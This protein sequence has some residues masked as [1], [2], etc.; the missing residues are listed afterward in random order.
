[1]VAL[2]FVL[3]SSMAFNALRS[4][5]PDQ[6][7]QRMGGSLRVAAMGGGPAAEL[8]PG[9]TCHSEDDWVQGYVDGNS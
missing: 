2:R 1:M 9:L 7:K 4:F 8:P 5:A 3:R 6:L